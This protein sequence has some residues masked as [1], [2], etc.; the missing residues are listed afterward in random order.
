[1]TLFQSILKTRNFNSNLIQYNKKL[2]KMA[3]FSQLLTIFT[4]FQRNLI[5]SE[6][7]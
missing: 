2:T 1:M 7:G 4:G 5:R 6:K 3:I